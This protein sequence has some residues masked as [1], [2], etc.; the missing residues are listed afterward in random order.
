MEPARRLRR[1]L[2]V[3]YYFPPAGGPAVQRVLK[4]VKYLRGYGYEPTVLTVADGAYP[5]RDPTLAADVPEGVVVHRTRS[6]DPFGLYARLTG[7]PK[8]EAVPVG[9]I[10]G[11]SR[12]ERLAR[13]GRANVFL[14][15]ARV[16]WVPFAVRE[17]FRLHRE[18]PFDVVLTSGPPH[19]AHL[20]GRALKRR[21]GLPWVADFRDPWTGIN[22]YEELPMTEAARRLD[23]RLE[24]SVLREADR[25]VTVSPTWADGLATLAGRPRSEIVV[26]HN[27]F[28]EEDFEG[29]PRGPEAVARDRFVLAY[30]GSMYATRNPTTLWAALAALRDAGE[31]E[32]LRL[33]L[34]GGIGEDVRAALAA[35]RLDAVTE[36]VPYVPHD[37]AVR[38]MTQAALLLLVVDPCRTERGILTGKLYEYLASGRPVLALGPPDGDAARLLEE[39]GGG[40]LF[41]RG[42]V[43]G[44]AAFVR[45]HYA[46][47]AAGRP[48]EGASAEAVAPYSRRAETGQIAAVLDA[49][50]TGR[51]S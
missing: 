22:Y 32:E 34:V 3:T 12:A 27:G 38:A 2:V 37:E 23:R 33:R 5:Q 47:W 45:E 44:M 25:V 15:D 21:R 9:S 7:K 51:T 29:V 49:A 46:A 20:V 42:D 19:S 40:R 24:R 14:P 50:A 39:T 36:F 18:R 41:G 17:A 48:R 30:V 31:V 43:E 1:A 26:V 6:F 16:G 28:D 8:A 10:G 13:W 4:T 11:G 35:A